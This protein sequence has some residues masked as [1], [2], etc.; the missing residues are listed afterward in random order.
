MAGL[1]RAV[2]EGYAERGEVGIVDST[3]HMLKFI[4]FQEMYFEDKFGPEFGI[5]S[6]QDLRNAPL[7]MRPEG[8]M[9][10]PEPGRPLEG[11]EMR[12]FVEKTVAE[13]AKLLGLEEDK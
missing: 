10:F 7:L 1:K 9:R 6:R 2:L 8:I 5:R 13:I 11:E 12:L 3:A 4:Y